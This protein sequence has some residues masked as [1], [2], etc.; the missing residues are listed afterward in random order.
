MAIVWYQEKQYPITA[1]ESVLDT[2]LTNLF[3]ESRKGRTA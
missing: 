1:G 2:L 3:D